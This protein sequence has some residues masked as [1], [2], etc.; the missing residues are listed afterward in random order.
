MGCILACAASGGTE[1][2]IPP[3]ISDDLA[4]LESAPP[5]DPHPQLEALRARSQAIESSIAAATVYLPAYDVKR[6]MRVCVCA[7]ARAASS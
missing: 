6:A 7:R 2:A 3:G 1:R 4:R 5:A